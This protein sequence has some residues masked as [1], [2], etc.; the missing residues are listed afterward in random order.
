MAVIPESVRQQLTDRFGTVLSGPVKL[1]V[2]TRPG[3]SRLILPAGLG[4]PTCEDAR[5]MAELL[6]DAAPEKITLEVVDVSRDSAR[7]EI[8][9]VTDVPTIAVASDG[10]IGRIRFQGLPTGTEFPALID[11]VERVS[12]AEHGLSQESLDA[13]AELTEPTEVMVFATPT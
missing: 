7:V 8:D 12:R 10:E 3:S 6:R 5:Q 2:Y 11:A 4:C 1:T 13:L 9:E